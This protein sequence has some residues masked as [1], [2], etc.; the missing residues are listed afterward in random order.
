MNRR[1][2]LLAATT[3]A[4]VLATRPLL[5]ATTPTPLALVTAD[6]AAHVAAVDPTTGRVVRRISTRSLPRSIERVGT[7][8]LVAHSELGHITLIDQ[9]DLTARSVLGRLAEPR[10]TAAHPDG[11]HAFVTDSGLNEVV[12]VDVLRGRVV[13]R[14]AVGGPARHLTLDPSGRR[15]WAALGTKADRIAIVDV[16]D[17]RNPR[18][19]RTVTPPFLA[20]D[21]VYSPTG[22]R[23]WI[24]SGDRGVVAIYDAA[25]RRL[26]RRIPADAP[27][28]HLAFSERGRVAFVASGDD[29]TMRVHDLDGRLLRTARIPVGSF[30]VTRGGGHVVTPSLSRGTLCV[31]DRNG[32]VRRTVRVS[33]AAHDVCMI[34][35]G[36]V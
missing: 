14:V 33:D 9:D 6:T 29:G 1:Q 3:G 28:Q 35:D 34:R 26:L 36:G 17:P 23:V 2:F 11:R 22:D 30:N 16:A 8:A 4:A 19:R 18:L 25:T 5:G 15:L 27:P 32:R 20:H 24:T 7:T 21:V 12:T 13:G 10:Y 31:L